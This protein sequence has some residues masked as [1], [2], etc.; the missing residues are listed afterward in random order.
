M[1]EARDRLVGDPRAVVDHAQARAAGGGALE[2]HG[3]VPAGRNVA[4]EDLAAAVAWVCSDEAPMLV[5][6]VLHLDGGFGAGAWRA[7][8]D[9]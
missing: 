9:G 5:G 4:P 2:Q 8:L 3:H 7:V 6:Q 1:Q